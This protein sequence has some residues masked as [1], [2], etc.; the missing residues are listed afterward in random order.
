MAIKRVKSAKKGQLVK[1]GE[2][3]ISYCAVLEEISEL[4]QSVR[5]T[6]ARVVNMIM[7]AVYWEIERRVVEYEQEGEARAGYG[8]KIRG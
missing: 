2:D 4:L 8:E 7:T 1:R 3:A 5:R 6:S